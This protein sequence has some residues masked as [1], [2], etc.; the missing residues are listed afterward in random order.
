MGQ[1][2]MNRLTK[3]EQILGVSALAF[4]ILSFLKLWA[5]VEAGAAGVSNTTRFSAWD[6]YGPLLKFGLFFALVAAGLV[7]A[8]M[9]GVDLSGLPLRLGQLYLALAGATFLFTLL[10]LAIGP[11]ESA[12]VNLPGFKVEVSRGLGLF[13]GTLLAAA[14]AAGAWMH[15]QGEGGSLPAAG[16]DPAVPPPA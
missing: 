11:D 10:T 3:G 7:A 9:A 4:F 1:M 13:I 14:M 8:K 6:A 16:T 12:N 15:Y 2:D 5:K